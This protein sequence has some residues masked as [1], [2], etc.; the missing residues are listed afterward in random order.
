MVAAAAFAAA[1][2]GPLLKPTAP[3]PTPWRARSYPRSAGPSMR[4]ESGGRRGPSAE[5][6]RSSQEL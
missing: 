1:A 3:K 4:L 2:E 5:P 6:P